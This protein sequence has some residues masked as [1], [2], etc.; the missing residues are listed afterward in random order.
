[1][2]RVLLDE[3]VPRLLASALNERGHQ[4]DY[5]P[6]AL[7]QM[8]DGDLLD[9]ALANGYDCL[10]TADKNMAH[11]QSLSGRPIAV[12]VLPTNNW[13]RVRRLVRFIATALFDLSPGEFTLIGEAGTLSAIETEPGSGTRP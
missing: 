11:Q 7:K 13:P 4:V 8:P 6:N 9:H 10:I 5:F 1:M 3:G 12:L 2:S